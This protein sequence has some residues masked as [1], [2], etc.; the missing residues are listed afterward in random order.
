MEKRLLKRVKSIY[1]CRLKQAI[2]SHHRHHPI[3]QVLAGC[4]L[5]FLLWS[6]I[7]PYANC[8]IRDEGE[9]DEEGKKERHGHES[10]PGAQ[11]F[12]CLFVV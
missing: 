9:R 5:L 12:V 3:I 1:D 7:Q 11:Q 10:S 6:L 8:A 4:S 2:A